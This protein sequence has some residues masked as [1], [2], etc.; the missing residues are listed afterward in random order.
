M[1]TKPLSPIDRMTH[2]EYRDYL[3]PL[4]NED[5]YP[6]NPNVNRIN[7]ACRSAFNNGYRYS[8]HHA[9]PL[10]QQIEELKKEVERLKEAN[11]EA[12]KLGYEAGLA[13]CQSDND[14]LR[15][16]L[17]EC[18]Y[19]FVSLSGEAP[20]RISKIIQEALQSNT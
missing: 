18:H 5:D 17:K 13:M 20:A 4:A 19:V 6:E 12:N 7:S 15:E 14:R 16:A 2:D 9:A 8:Q 10:L 11:T 3:Y 1:E